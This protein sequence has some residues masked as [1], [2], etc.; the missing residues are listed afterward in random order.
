MERRL[1]E[2]IGPSVPVPISARMIFRELFSG[3][4]QHIVVSEVADDHMCHGI[5]VRRNDAGRVVSFRNVDILYSIDDAYEPD[6]VC[7]GGRRPQKALD[8]RVL[9]IVGGPRD[10]PSPVPSL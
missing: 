3:I 2:E 6:D 10:L 7:F 4:Q 5:D 1:Q 9:E 8:S